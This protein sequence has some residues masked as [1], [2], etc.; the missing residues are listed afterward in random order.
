LIS[1]E[2]PL[3]GGFAGEIASTIQDMCF[4]NLESPI[5]RV[6]GLDTP[7]PLAHEKEYLPDH[8]K[9]FEAIKRSVNY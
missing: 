4:L 6:C 7:F 8:L 9:I 2:A 5:A 1:H 3:T